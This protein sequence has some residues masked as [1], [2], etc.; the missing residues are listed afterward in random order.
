MDRMF[1]AL[2]LAAGLGLAGCGGGQ[3]SGKPIDPSSP[4]SVEEWRKI[5]EAHVKF[6]PD[7][8]ERLKKGNPKLNT[9][10]GWDAFYRA[11]VAK[12]K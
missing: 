1:A 7:T 6:D 2:V 10:A 8:F 11:E 9:R 5:D 4:L 12:K 3:P